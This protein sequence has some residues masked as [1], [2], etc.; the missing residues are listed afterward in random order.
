MVASPR[1][2]DQKEWPK[3]NNKMEKQSLGNLMGWG[4]LENYYM[5]ESNKILLGNSR[6][7]IPNSQKISL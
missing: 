4:G 3:G 5:I 6:I 7:P 1:S 2:N